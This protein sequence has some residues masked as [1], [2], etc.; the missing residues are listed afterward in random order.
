MSNNRL[1]RVIGLILIGIILLGSVQTRTSAQQEPLVIWMWDGFWLPLE[2]L[3]DRYGV[4]VKIEVLSS[5]AIQERFPAEARSGSGPDIITGSDDWMFPFL[6]DALLEPLDLGGRTAD[7]VPFAI[8]AM[9]FEGQ[10]FGLPFALESL[11]FVR[12]PEL[13]PDAPATWDEVRAIS[14]QLQDSG[15]A[16][17]GFVLHDYD[18]YHFYPILS[19]YGSYVYGQRSDGTWDTQ[20]IGLNNDGAVAA[21]TWLRDMTQA[22]LIPTGLE[23]EDVHIA[24]ETGQAAMIITGPWAI[25]RFQE[26]GIPYTVSAFPAGIQPGSPFVHVQ[27]LMVNAH[28][29]HKDAARAFVLDVLSSQESMLTI[30]Q[31]ISRLPAHMGVYEQVDDPVLLGFA[32]ALLDGQR[33]PDITLMDPVW[34]IQDPIHLARTG[35]IDPHT[36]LDDAVNAIREQVGKP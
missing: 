11:A 13:V 6:T 3:A 14:Q 15:Q 36:A 27:G 35:E 5:E 32:E 17:Y 10:L 9:S 1:I 2:E 19:A 20:D 28:T 26:K 12:N 23:W 8:E 24:F 4:P 25:W 31:N 18:L 21:V 16:S 30:Y 29:P 34:M 22:G 7:Y 33:M